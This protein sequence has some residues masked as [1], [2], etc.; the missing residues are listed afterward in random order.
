VVEQLDPS[1]EAGVPVQDLPTLVGRPD[2]TPPKL[3]DEYNWI[4]ITTGINPTAQ[5]DRNDMPAP[6]LDGHSGDLVAAL[7]ALARLTAAPGLTSWIGSAERELQGV[8][9]ARVS[10]WLQRA[11]AGGEALRAALVVK[12]VAG[13]INVIVHALGILTSLPYILEPGEIVESLS[14]G[15]GNTGRD[16]D[17]TTNLRIAEFKFI[18]WRGGSETI[19]QNGLFAD[20]FNLVA[21]PMPRRKM[22]YVVGVEQPLR[23]LAN[24]RALT[25]VMS[26]NS[27]LA[28]RFHDRYG[29]QFTTVRDYYESVHDQVKIVDLATIVPGLA[30]A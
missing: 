14:L 18:E 11:P 29:D 5:P 2:S 21:D 17:L 15:A 23:F 10:D 12:R 22:L 8:D 9:A 25:S 24:R 6:D 20:L 26:R 16:H 19:R 28:K 7:E 4:V 30:L 13:Q 1:A 3:I 27:N